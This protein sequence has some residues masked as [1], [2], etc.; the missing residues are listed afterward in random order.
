MRYAVALLLLL[1]VTTHARVGPATCFQDCANKNAHDTF[2]CV[3]LDLPC[4]CSLDNGHFL[5]K[6]AQCLQSTCPEVYS[7]GR[8]WFNTNSCHPKT[9]TPITIPV[10]VVVPTPVII[11]PT[12]IVPLTVATVVATPTPPATTTVAT[13]TYTFIE[14]GT[15]TIT[16]A[17]TSA[18]TETSTI[19]Q[20]LDYTT[21]NTIVELTAYNTTITSPITGT[22]TGPN[23]T[24]TTTR[25]TTQT[26]NDGNTMGA[27]KLS[28]AM[29]LGFACV[30]I[31]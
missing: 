17:T 16:T 19:T 23:A 4:Y 10:S 7:I 2:T 3:G 29:A 30:F 8:S 20:I 22:I 14:T 9:N 27:N 28:F 11:V 13:T 31:L 24:S 12:P 18:V 26:I 21:T 6:F 5:P 1:A 25:V 15:I